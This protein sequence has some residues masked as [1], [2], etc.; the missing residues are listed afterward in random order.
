MLI[1]I[2]FLYETSVDSTVD[3]TVAELVEI[4]NLQILEGQFSFANFTRLT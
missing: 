2:Q 1:P 4:W 3:N